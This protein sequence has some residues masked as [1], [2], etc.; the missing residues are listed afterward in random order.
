MANKCLVTKLDCLI[1]KDI[2]KLGVI[3][4]KIIGNQSTVG[5]Y[6]AIATHGRGVVTFV[7]EDKT[8]QSFNLPSTQYFNFS[9][10]RIGQTLEIHNYYAL[11]S[12]SA[13]LISFDIKAF[14]FCTWWSGEVN[15]R[16]SVQLTGDISS[17]YRLTDVT[18]WYFPNSVEGSVN[19]FAQKMH[20]YGKTSGTVK[21][22]GN[23]TTKIKANGINL[24]TKTSTITFDSSLPD[25][26]SVSDPT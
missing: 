14:A 2:D 24:G 3:K 13:N 19:E 11:N 1:D 20:E 6:G 12:L 4:A 7:F 16:G 26:F 5:S 25:G 15:L 8:T 18:F 9:S 17:L 22:V 10:E 23:G 21:I